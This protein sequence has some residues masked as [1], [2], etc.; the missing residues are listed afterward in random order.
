MTNYVYLGNI[1]GPQGYSVETALIRADDHLQLTLSD[2]EIIDAGVSRGAQGLPGVNAVANDTATAG[3][4]ETT[5]TSATRSALKATL[6]QGVSVT[7]PKYGAVADWNGT[8]G[9]DNL[10][11]FN[12]AFADVAHGGRVWVPAGRYYFSDTLNWPTTKAFHFDCGVG[13][14]ISGGVYGTELVFAAG[15]TGLSITGAGFGSK[16]GPFAITSLSTAAGTD[17]GVFV[18]ATRTLI[19]GAIVESFGSHGVHVKA[20][21]AY[22]GGNANNTVVHRVRAS[23]NRGDGIRIEGTDANKV[24][25]SKADVVS[26]YGWGINLISCSMCDV[27]GAHADQ[28]YNSAPGA[29]RDAGNSNNWDWLYS[30]GGINFTI[31]TGSS[32]GRLTMSSYGNPALV[33]VGNGWLSWFIL[34]T[35]MSPILNVKGVVTGTKQYQIRGDSFAVGALDLIQA[36]DNKRILSVDGGVGRALWFLSQVPSADASWSI[37]SSTARWLNG[38]FSSYIRMGAFA[39]GSRPSAVTAGVGAVC[40]DSTLSKPI[41]SDGSIW[42]DAMGTAV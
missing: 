37:G 12:A 2:G 30:E 15:K 14:G 36:T 32:N 39:T 34:N 18:S 35:G 17:V 42:R 25:V 28:Q 40:Y 26:N 6:A 5:G 11:A 22:G 1:R 10:A 21:V 33:V 9:T 41:Y 31:D 13:G 23:G 27:T 7:D 16:V 19:D 3:Y 38:F 20:G 4:V 24:T 29:Y 8:T